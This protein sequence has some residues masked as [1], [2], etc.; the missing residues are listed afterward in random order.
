MQ[1][2]ISNGK[3]D[4]L[5]ITKCKKVTNK[6]HEICTPRPRNSP[7]SEVTSSSKKPSD[8]VLSSSTLDHMSETP[9]DVNNAFMHAWQSSTFDHIPPSPDARSIRLT[10]LFTVLQG[11]KPGG[12]PKL[13]AAGLGTWSR[14]YCPA[15]RYNYMTSN[16]AECID[17]I[18][19]DIHKL[20]ITRLVDR[21]RETSQNWF[22]NCHEKYKDN[23]LRL[24]ED[25][26]D[27]HIYNEDTYGPT[28]IDADCYYEETDSIKEVQVSD[29]EEEK[30][31]KK[32]VKPS[33]KWINFVKVT[34]D[35]NPRETVKNGEQPKQNTYR[36]RAVNVAK[37]K[38][39]HK[40]VKGKRG[41][42]VKASACWGNLQ[43]HLQDKGVID[44]G[45]SR[46]MTWNIFILI[47][48]EEIDGGYVAFRGNPK[49]GKITS[50]G[51][52]DETSGTLK[53]FITMVENQMNL[54][55]KVIR[56]DNGTEFKNREMNQFYEVKGIMRQYSVA[57]TPQQNG[58]AERRNMKLIKAAR[59]M[60]ADS[61]LPTTFWA[62][63][64]NTACYVQSRVLVIEP[65]NK[66]PYELFYGRTLAISFLKPFGCLVTIFNTIDHLGK[67]DGKA[68]E[69]SFVGYSLNSKAFRIF[70]SR[71]RIMKENLHVSFSENTLNNVCSGPNWLF[72]IDALTKIMNYQP[73]VAQSN[74]FSCT[75]ASNGEKD[76]TNSTNKVN[77]AT[78]NINATSF[79]RVNDVGT[80]I[81]IN[82]PLD[83]YM[84]SLEDIII[85]ED[86]HDDEDVFEEDVYVFQPPRFEDPDF[87]DKVYKV[88]KAFYGLHQAPRA[89]QDIYVV[90]ILKKFGLLDVK[91][92]S[93]PMETSKPLLKDE[94]G[95]EVDVHMYRSMIG[96]LMYLTSS[97]PDFMFDCKKQTVV[98][99]SITEA[100]YVAASSCCGQD[101]WLQALIDR[102]K[103]VVNEASIK[104]DLKLNDTEVRTGF[105]RAVTPL[106]GTIMVQARD[107]PTDVQDTPIPDEPS[108]SQPQRKYKPRR[109]QRMETEVSPS[110]TNTKEH[111]P[112]PSNNPLPSGEDRLKLKELMELCSNLLNKVLDLEN[113]VIE[114]KSSH[115]A[116]I[117]ELESRVEKLDDENV[118]LTKELKRGKI[119]D[120]DA[121]VEVNLKN[122][123]KLDMAHEET[124]L[125]M[126]DV[127][128]QSKRIED[129]VKDVK[130]IVAIAENVEGINADTIS[131]ISKDDVTLA[132]TLI[133]IKE[134]KP[135]AKGVIM[136]EPSEFRK[137]L[138]S[139]SSLPFQAKDK[140]LEMDAERIKAPR[141][142]TRKEKVDKY[143]PA[144]KQKGDELEKDNAKKQKLEEQKEAKEPKKNL[145]I[146]PDDEDDVFMNVTPLSY[147]PPTIVDY[148]IYKERKKEHFQ[149]F[150]A[151]GNHP[152]YLAFSTM[153]K[154]FDRED[155]EVLWKI[156]KDRFRKSQPKEVLDVFYGIL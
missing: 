61:K 25:Y 29:D 65:H 75:K 149:I 125:S 144:K 116:K 98:G 21:Q 105:S 30:I 23:E 107:L 79:S 151:N 108:S 84:P 62:E 143:Q 102:K 3:V 1:L 24:I 104:H 122:V 13:L 63:A 88:K 138:P 118:S 134:V 4:T 87:P 106:F 72:D 139:Q 148:K 155:L 147:T 109:K 53:S 130:D 110:E 129:V 38:A 68:E 114:M 44:I 127:D 90:E 73:V 142:R 6:S 153:L 52:K 81:S 7:Q 117:E 154:N 103:V 113:E 42:A 27:S 16:N 31:E 8:Y 10:L 48:Y 137:T 80:N 131:Q 66:T 145:E 55:V 124:V 28:Y 14:A 95:E 100:E 54:K 56:C 58:V 45:C 37:A 136:Q 46:H 71:T 33:I 133:K 19:K 11:F 96:S 128:V 35:N 77:T 132:Q 50:K 135:K 9:R 156:V 101:V 20:P 69:G 150:R 41:N 39:K 97:R 15:D 34:T 120:I 51:I 67:F 2:A 112:T 140:G 126:Q 89:C 82:L 40:A 57:R 5:V 92:T 152:M 59:T 78:S 76:N 94:D 43:E 74:D 99:N 12:F 70:N 115:K 93:A 146:V 17:S 91:K 119:V 32:K 18:T 83:A 36:K 141:K 111:V 26:G 49:R 85:F 60:L 86:S 64:V 22:T 47:D 121:D 123:Y